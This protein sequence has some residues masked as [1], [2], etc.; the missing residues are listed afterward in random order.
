MT[1]AIGND[2][3]WGIIEW[4]VTGLSTAA[5]GAATFVLRLASKLDRASTAIEWQKT[6]VA[7]AKQA[8]DAALLRLS[9]RIAELHDEH[10]RLR[11]AAAALPTRTDLRDMEERLGERLAALAT[12]I[13]GLL[14]DRGG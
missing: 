10:C 11:E 4:T 3:P 8:A 5:L 14:D 12:R 13:D 2:A 7:A 6:E 9:D 1:F